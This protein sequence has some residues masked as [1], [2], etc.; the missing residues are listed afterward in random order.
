[1]Y[2]LIFS[3]LGIVITTWI[4]PRKNLWASTI[5]Q[6]STI[7]IVSNLILLPINSPFLY[8]NIFHADSISSPLILLSF[9]LLP[10]S[11]LASIS[12]LQNTSHL[13]QQTFITLLLFILLALI[14][15]F[16]SSN[17]LLFFIGFEST[18]IPTLFLITNWGMNEARIEAGYYFIFYTLISSLPLLLAL[19]SIYNVNNHLNI[20]IF[21]YFPINTNNQ[22]LTVACL[23]AFLVKV[24]I[25]GF[26]LWL[27]K[28]HVE[29][30]VAGSMIL[31]AILLKMGGYGLIRLTTILNA[32]INDSFNNYLI[33]FC[34][35]G[36]ALTSLICITQTDL[37]ALIAYSSV[38]HMSFMVAAIASITSWGVI[39]SLIVMI[40]HGIVSSG[41]FCIANIFYERSGT[42]T[43]L[44]NRN[45]K[46][47][48]SVT[49]LIWLVLACAN[50]GLPP[51][52]NS[53]GEIIVFSSVS[54]NSLTN[55]VPCL[56]GVLFTGI[57]SLTIYQLTNSGTSFSWHKNHS[58]HSEREILSLFL[59]LTPL[60]LL[61][62]S[63]NSLTI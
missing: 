1:M 56:L 50:L 31:A 27:P 46:N 63:I 9:W 52:P 58:P 23:T 36:G 37:K 24:P 6:A 22:I 53:I 20:S 34:C 38:S 28:A 14:I 29:A 35:W 13:N 43:L 44:I 25:F 33:P 26:H 5:S 17:I 32:N 2:L 8:N 48:F 57:F 60:I 61:I 12:H 19:I 51:L 15:T 11:L 54:I 45:I 10:V 18:L 42:R 49:P 39:G 55:F 40:A 59:H 3:T 62:I 41:L 21:N 4:I 30:P 7:L 47:I 16:T